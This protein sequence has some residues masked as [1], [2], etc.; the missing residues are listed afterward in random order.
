MPPAVVN[1]QRHSE[2]LVPPARALSMLAMKQ[3]EA[4]QQ[5]NFGNLTNLLK[6]Y[7]VALV[8]LSN[9]DALDWV[10]CHGDLHPYNVVVCRDDTEPTPYLLDFES[11][12][13]CVPEYDI[14]KSIV[15]GSA[16]S[17]SDVNDILQGL[18]S[19]AFTSRELIDALVVFHTVDGWLYAGQLEKRDCE[20]WDE[21]LNYVLE[22]YVA[23]F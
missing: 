21:K 6:R 23:S 12:V 10:W 22:N 9:A 17:G 14:A 5:L 8:E 3:I 16:L 4:L 1:A 19:N 13:Q 7:F 2:R 20:L 11:A 15:T 18:G